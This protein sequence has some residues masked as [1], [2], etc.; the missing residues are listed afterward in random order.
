MGAHPYYYFTPYQEDIGAALQALRDQE[1]RAGRYDPAMRNA[2]PPLYMFQFRFPPDS[3]SPAPG[4][5]HASLQQAFDN[6][7]EAGTGSI[8]DLINVAD[9]PDS[10][11]LSPVSDSDLQDLFGTA[12]PTRADVERVLLNAGALLSD[13]GETALDFWEMIDRGEGR[14]IVLYQDGRPAELFMAGYSFD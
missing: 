13:D 14:Y 3:S 8:L 5:V 2:N 10:F 11:T 4:P 12:Q 7:D 9:D 1:F 6:M